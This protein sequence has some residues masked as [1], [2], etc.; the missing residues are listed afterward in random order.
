MACNHL[1]QYQLHPLLFPSHKFSRL[2]FFKLE[3]L[4]EPFELFISASLATK[5][6]YISQNYL[7]LS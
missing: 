1:L 3:F 2:F 7:G 6:R 5:S 4:M